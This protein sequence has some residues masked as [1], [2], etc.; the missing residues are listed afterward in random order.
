MSIFYHF[1]AKRFLDGIQR[2]GLTEGRMVKTMNPPTFLENK[3]W[4]TTN[5]SFDQDWA[6]GT[7]RLP[8]KRNEVRLTI[9]IPLEALENC[10][11][12]SQMR[13][14]T[15]EVAKDLEAYGDPENWHIYQGQIKPNWILKVDFNPTLN[16]GV[17]SE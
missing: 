10:K 16:Q 7:G 5:P 14:L 3:Q 6:I 11:P 15:P 12:W 1:T 13:F 17:V 9:K 4:I 2:S 8:Y